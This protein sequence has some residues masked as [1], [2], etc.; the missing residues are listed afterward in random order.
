[1]SV[2]GDIIDDQSA[3][4]LR[5]KIE[6]NQLRRDIGG[7]PHLSDMRQCMIDAADENIQLRALC[8]ESLRCMK[9]A[10]RRFAPTTTNSD[11]DNHIKKLAEYLKESQND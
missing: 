10:K 6:L 8:K 3:E 5:L 4:I 7:F 11:A 9:E 1:M 2:S